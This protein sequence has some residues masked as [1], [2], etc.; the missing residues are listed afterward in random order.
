MVFVLFAIGELIAARDCDW[1]SELSARGFKAL[2]VRIA[3]KVLGK[4]LL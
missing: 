4:S 3:P 1:G 2:S